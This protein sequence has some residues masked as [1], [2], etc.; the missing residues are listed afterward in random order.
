M[1]Q[2]LDEPSR[3]RGRYDGPDTMT[4]LGAFD[5]YDDHRSEPDGYSSH[6]GKDHH[7]STGADRLDT[8]SHP[9]RGYESENNEFTGHPTGASYSQ[10]WKLGHG[11]NELDDFGRVNDFDTPRATPFTSQQAGLSFDAS[12]VDHGDS[13]SGQFGGAYPGSLGRDQGMRFF[14]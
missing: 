4:Q 6:A 14:A 12:D 1:L 2:D 11:S 13:V 3:H 5:E 10:N 9:S 8:L 7:G